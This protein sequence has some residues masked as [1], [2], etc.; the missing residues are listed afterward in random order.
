MPF[1]D[2][3]RNRFICYCFESDPQLQECKIRTQFSKTF[4]VWKMIISTAHLHLNTENN[5]THNACLKA[6]NKTTLDN[7]IGTL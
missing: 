1:C 5:R 2:M 4:C 3:H 6:T 7:E